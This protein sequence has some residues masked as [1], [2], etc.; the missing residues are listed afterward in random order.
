MFNCCWC[1][2]LYR[3]L[4]LYFFSFFNRCSFS[5]FLSVILRFTSAFLLCRLLLFLSLF[6][7]LYLLFL[8]G[9]H[10][11]LDLRLWS[12]RLFFLLYLLNLLHFLNHF[13]LFCLFGL[14]SLSWTTSL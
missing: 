4:S 5:S 1:S 11:L 9:F 13:H 14:F 8:Y 12:C 7:R 2:N 10:W 6:Y 3:F